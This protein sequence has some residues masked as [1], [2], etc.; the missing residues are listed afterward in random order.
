MEHC[1]NCHIKTSIMIG[2]ED[3]T[4]FFSKSEDRASIHDLSTSMK[5]IK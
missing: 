1:I 4:Y 3:D 5:P 2:N